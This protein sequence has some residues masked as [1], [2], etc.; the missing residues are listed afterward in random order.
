MLP[1]GSARGI[2]RHLSIRNRRTARS[3]HTIQLRKRTIPSADVMERLHSISRNHNLHV[4]S[5]HAVLVKKRRLKALLNAL[6]SNPTK[7]QSKK[8]HHT[9]R[10]PGPAPAVSPV[11]PQPL[12]SNPSSPTPKYPIASNLSPSTASNTATPPN[13]ALAHPAGAVGALKCTSN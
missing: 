10:A 13:S 11:Q 9:L 5:H 6:L 3:C 8:Q 1:A 7:A 12:R 4:P 2:T